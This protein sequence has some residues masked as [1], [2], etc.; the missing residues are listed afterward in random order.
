[1]ASN[2]TTPLRIEFRDIDDLQAVSPVEESPLVGPANSVSRLPATAHSTRFAARQAPALPP[3]AALAARQGRPLRIA[4]LS[5]FTRISYANGAVFQT[6]FLYQELRRCGHEVT[7][8]GPHDPDATPEELAPGT[9]ELPSVPLK[10]YPGLHLPMPLAPWIFDP[11][12]WNFDVVFAQT[13]PLLLEF[14]VWLRKMK[15]IP[16]LCVNTTHL[17][18]A[19]DVLLPEKLSKNDLVQAGVLMTLTR[20]YERLFSRIYNQSDGLVVLSEGLRAYWRERGVTTPI[21]VIPRT[22]QPEIFDQPLKTDP[23]LELIDR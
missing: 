22:V 19:Y 15:G 17:V 2:P 20:P 8:I 1:M 3:F 10:T 23:Y 14:G 13:T 12:R 5:D 11:N 18:A 7:V 21:H 6:R 4:I 9:V 16:L